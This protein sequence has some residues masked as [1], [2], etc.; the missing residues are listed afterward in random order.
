[1]LFAVESDFLF[2]RRSENKCYAIGTDKDKCLKKSRKCF[3]DE[4]DGRC[5]PLK[6]KHG[7]GSIKDVNQCNQSP[8]GCFWDDEDGRCER[9]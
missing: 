3:W 4:E 5:E 6:D 2:S 7:C 8:K 1:M 9:L